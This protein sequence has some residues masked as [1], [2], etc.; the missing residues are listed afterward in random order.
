MKDLSVEGLGMVYE[1]PKGGSVQALHDASFDLEAGRLLTLPGPSGCGK[2]TLLNTIVGF[3]TPTSSSATLGGDPIVVLDQER[4][5]ICQ[6][7]ALNALPDI[8]TGMCLVLSVCWGALVVA[9]FTGTTK[10]LGAMIFAASKFFGM[11]IVVVSLIIVG[12]IGVTMD[13]IMRFSERRLIPW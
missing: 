6:R 9:E 7:L 11:D 8:F 4:G 2:T 1:L 12:V 5:R 3:L 10:G 13:P